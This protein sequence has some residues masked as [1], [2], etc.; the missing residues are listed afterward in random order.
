MTH[1]SPAPT[2]LSTERDTYDM[3]V[4]GGGITGAA[5]ARDA[6]LRGLKVAL[7]EKSDWGSGTSSKSSKLIHG[8]LR[9]LEH[10]EIGLVFESVSE[11]AVQ[12]KVAPHLVRPLPFLVPIY[13]DAKPGLELMNVGLW[14]YDTLA[15]F[16]APT[17]HRVFRGKK[18]GDL[19][20]A[21]ADEEL[22][23][24]IEYYD[25]VTD[26]AR[27]VLENIIDARD[28]GA[29]C[30][31][32]TT[33]TSFE[34]DNDGRVCG[35]NAE[36]GFTGEARQLRTRS[37]IVAAGAWT[38][39]VHAVRDRGRRSVDRRGRPAN[40]IGRQAR[41]PAPHKGRTHRV[42]PRKAA[43]A[44]GYYADFA[45]RR[46]SHVRHSLEGPDGPRHHRH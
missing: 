17:M 13:K 41:H 2:A 30:H 5:I 33:V 9:Y 43:A 29:E 22:K 36:D 25:C 35:V 40:R 32:Y 34:R 46:P 37:V 28:A 14:I 4:L 6:A 11:R 31:S 10:G 12:R 24:A 19:E 45:G 38:D 1:E 8:G 39:E 18:A 20:P 15:L 7:F 44:P 27:L 42:P 26:D 16:R 3:V 23:G 21:L